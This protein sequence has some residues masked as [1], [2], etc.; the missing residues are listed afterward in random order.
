MKDKW[1]DD[2]FESICPTCGQTFLK[3]TVDYLLRLCH[4]QDDLLMAYRT[5]QKR[6]TGKS[7]DTI[8][9]CKEHLRRMNVI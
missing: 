4:A 2:R 5:G 7:I 8:H 6:F 9:I 1:E 3:E